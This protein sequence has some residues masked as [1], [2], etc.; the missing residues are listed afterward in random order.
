MEFV[1]TP[2]AVF[3]FKVAGW[4]AIGGTA[5]WA[6]SRIWQADERKNDWKKA[7]KRRR[8]FDRG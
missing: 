4:L 7:A 6:L 5:T 2:E 8:P 3:W 1:V